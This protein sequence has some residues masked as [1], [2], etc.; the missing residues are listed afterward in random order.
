MISHN[1]SNCRQLQH[2]VHVIYGREKTV[3]AKIQQYYHLKI[4]GVQDETKDSL[5]QVVVEFV[6]KKKKLIPN[7]P[8]Q[9]FLNIKSLF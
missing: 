1:L 7:S 2:D 8:K 9:S 4:V 6:R 3:D 5:V